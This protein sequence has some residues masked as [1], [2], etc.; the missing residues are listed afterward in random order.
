MQ[1]LLSTETLRRRGIFN[2]P[3]VERL[4]REHITGY[5]DHSTKLWGLMS[6]EM[7][8]RKF[9]DKDGGYSGTTHGSSAAAAP[10]GCGVHI[11]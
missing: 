7:W 9:I 8:T 3:L 10:T 4:V 2:I 6:V 11:S 1:D 5:S